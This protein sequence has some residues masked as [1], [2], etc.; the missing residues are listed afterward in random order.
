[1]KVRLSLRRVRPTPGS[2]LALFTEFS[3]HPLVTEREGTTLELEADH[4]A[5]ANVETVIRDL[6]E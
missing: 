5:H 6:K 3:Y 2:Q 1:M 4:R